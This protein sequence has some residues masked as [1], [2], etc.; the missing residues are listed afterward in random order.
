MADRHYEQIL[1]I[2]K[3]HGA[4]LVRQTKHDVWKFPDGT[5]WTIAQSPSCPFS[6]QKNLADLR[7]KLGLNDPNRG[8]PGERREA[9]SSKR[10]WKRQVADVAEELGLTGTK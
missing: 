3:S 7:N 8:Q 1:E 6:Y 9:K 4:V 2:L 10:P 5:A